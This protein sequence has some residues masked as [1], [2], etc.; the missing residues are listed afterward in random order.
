[1]VF[2]ACRGGSPQTR[3]WT[4]EVRDAVKL[5]KESYQVLLAR[6][7]PEAADGNRQAKPTAA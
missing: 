2:A 7:T 5:E 4:P 1:M 6:W 3:W